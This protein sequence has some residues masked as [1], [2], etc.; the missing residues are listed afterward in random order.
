MVRSRLAP[1]GTRD[2]EIWRMRATDG[3]KP[4]NLTNDPGGDF[5]PAWQPLP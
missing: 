1:D 3:A 5:Y 4:I 2:F